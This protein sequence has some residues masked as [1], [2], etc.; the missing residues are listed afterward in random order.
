MNIIRHTFNFL[1]TKSNLLSMFQF[2]VKNI[3][4][5]QSALVIFAL[6]SISNIPDRPLDS[7]PDVH[8]VGHWS[9]QEF[10]YIFYLRV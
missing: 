8:C 6:R 3:V 4:M 5:M 1:H 2:P 10:E 9:F 7:F